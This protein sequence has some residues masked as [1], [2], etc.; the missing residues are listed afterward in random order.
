MSGLRRTKRNPS[1][2]YDELGVGVGET[3]KLVL[4]QVHDE[5][6]VRGRQ[7]H[8]HLGEL[9]VE[10]AHVAARFLPRREDRERK[11]VRGMQL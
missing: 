7:L 8:H 4:V 6:L 3:L 1:D 10:V 9:L 2:L 11:R 5:E